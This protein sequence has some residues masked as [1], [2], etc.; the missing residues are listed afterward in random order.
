MSIGAWAPSAD[1]AAKTI[2]IEDALLQRFIV[3]SEQDQLE[4]LDTQISPEDSQ[5]WAGL[6]H[7]PADAWLAAGDSLDDDQL[8]HLIRFF[9]VVER[10]PGWEAGADSP[11]IPLA[12]LLRKRGT[13][14]DRD[15][16]AWIRSVSDNRFLP[17]GPL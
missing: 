13:R 15:F 8:L 5:T 3:L 14:L 10:L 6:M 9:T 4:S 1:A 11:V 12:K 16:L 2:D 7:L 17:Y